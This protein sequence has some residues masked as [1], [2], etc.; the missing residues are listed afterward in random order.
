MKSNAQSRPLCVDLDGTL[1]RSD[2]LA[3]SIFALI[4]KNPLY[5]F[6]LPFWLLSGKA[7]FKRRV[8]ERVSLD[9]EALPFSESFLRF[10]RGERA[11]SRPLVLATGSNEKLAQ[12]VADHLG[13]FERVLASTAN[14]NLS[15]RAK[16]DKLVELYGDGGFDYAGS[17]S[18]D[19]P[20]LAAAH[21]AI[22]VNPTDRVQKRLERDFED[23]Q[24]FDDRSGS[25]VLDYLFAV[26]AYQWLKNVVVFVPL[27]LAHRVSEAEL[28]GQAVL[29]FVAFSL[30]ASSVY[31]LN[32]LLDLSADRRHRS[33]RL[34][35]FAAG[36]IPIRHGFLM[37]PLLL[38]GAFA[39]S[40]YLPIEFTAVLG[41]YYLVT[42]AYSLRF[43]NSAPADV[44]IL[45]G[46]Y[47]LR[48]I[49]G[50]AAIE[51][52][53]S[54]WLL[55]FSMFFFLSLALAKRFTGLAAAKRA[56]PNAVGER[57]Y[58]I[59]DLDLLSQFGIASAFAAV[60]VLA[61][62]INSDAIQLLYRHPEVVWLLCPL[63]LYIVSRIWLLARRGDLDEDPVMFALRDTRTHIAVL[64]GLVLLW[65]AT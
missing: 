59:S 57:G 62:Y 4:K 58:V 65:V 61:L 6:A 36:L 24:V 50:A 47:T 28:V 14:V 30:C 54:F 25:R 8:A 38:C 42:V 29:S 13:V 10:L 39:V 64:T 55:A 48:V 12:A 40:W 22:L 15:G 16:R 17:E 60:L 51:V 46:L 1:L 21:S 45:A 33:K 52:V 32:D 49:G 31:V 11:I 43:K 9:V 34:R 27:I 53:P 44:L 7:N 37:A 26:R 41:F 3:E 23:V 2:L 63:L 56:D 18:A 35:P 5:L 19:L 20:I